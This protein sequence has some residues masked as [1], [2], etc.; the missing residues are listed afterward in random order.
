MAEDLNILLSAYLDGELTPSQAARLEKRL[1]EDPQARAMLADLR[2]VCGM[3]QNLPREKA[4]E[5]MAEQIQS[6]LER[7]SLLGRE[8]TQ[9]ESA[10]RNHLRIRRFIAAAAVIMLTGAIAGIV[11]NVLAP[12]K[13]ASTVPSLQSDAFV[14]HKPSF[15]LK[16][17][18]DAAAEKPG[19]EPE[20]QAA[21]MPAEPSRY[22]FIQLAATVPD[23]AGLQKMLPGILTG[24]GIE[25]FIRTPLE[26]A[27]QYSFLCTMGQLHRW[28]G[29][30]RRFSKQNIDV[31]LPAMLGNKPVV[32][33]QASNDQILIAV[34]LSQHTAP[35]QTPRDD[36]KGPSSVGP[37]P[38]LADNQPALP[39]WMADNLEAVTPEVGG[40]HLLG[41][42]TP[43]VDKS[44]PP[45]PPSVLQPGPTGD[46][47]WKD[48][49][50]DLVAVTFTLYTSHK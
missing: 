39:S 18:L 35:N 1:A 50:N 33:P 4:P 17:S 14:A 2:R 22:G 9:T 42:D 19:L 3:V 46:V 23:S 15:S 34:A 16:E 27:E 29:D 44:Q 36:E 21:S 43:P 32:V 40:L 24:N 37:I 49:A 5:D 30:W 7:D 26:S 8:D 10:G 11:Y 13:Q 6:L 48:R 20:G 31:V 41:P 45:C 25:R 47:A 28:L 38:L 12:P